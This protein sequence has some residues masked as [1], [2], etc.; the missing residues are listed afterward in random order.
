MTKK[1]SLYYL[2]AVITITVLGYL[3]TTMVK[4]PSEIEVAAI[5]MPAVIVEKPVTEENLVSGMNDLHNT[6]WRW[7]RTENATGTIISEPVSDKPFILN[8]ADD[9]SM[10]SQTDCNSLAGS[11]THADSSLI[12]GSLMSTKMFCEASQEQVYVA[13]LQAVSEYAIL[14]NM[15]LLSLKENTGMMYFV[16]VSQ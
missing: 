1:Q 7:L 3:Y 9:D 2:G 15:L 14:N 10:G 12:F 5:E 13:Q 8:F 16:K 4:A 11:Y 6:S